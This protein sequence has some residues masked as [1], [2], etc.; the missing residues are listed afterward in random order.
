MHS[1]FF[2]KINKEKISQNYHEKLPLNYG[3]VN[4]QTLYSLPYLY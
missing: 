4:I 1:V 2:M 3:F